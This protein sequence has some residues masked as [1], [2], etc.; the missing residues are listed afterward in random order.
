MPLARGMAMPNRW[1]VNSLISIHQLS[2]AQLM[3][4]A[5][6]KTRR[7]LDCAYELLYRKGFGGVGVDE[8]DASAGVTKRTLYYHFESKDELLAAVLNLHHE[9]ALARIRKYQHRYSGGA[10]DIVGLLFAELAKW[11]KKPGWTGGR[12]QDSRAWLWNSPTFPVTL[13]APLLIDTRRRW[14]AGTANYL[15]RP[16]SPRRANERERERERER[17][18]ALLAE[19]AIA[20]IL[21]HGDRRYAE[22]AHARRRDW[23]KINLRRAHRRCGSRSAAQKRHYAGCA[24]QSEKLRVAA[25]FCVGGGE[26]VRQK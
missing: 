18:I 20:L 1:F 4:R 9:L 24:S 12:E 3:P 6:E 10:A 17:E 5:S 14:R 23:S 22:T 2:Y 21:I 8:I 25:Q 15:R 26:G 13:L 7:I 19:G 11:S 16:A